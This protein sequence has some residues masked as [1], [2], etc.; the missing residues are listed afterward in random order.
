[1]A[2]HD[3]ARLVAASAVFASVL[4][5]ASMAFACEGAGVIVRIE[6][7]PQDVE[8]ARVENGAAILVSRPRVLEVVCRGDVIR[9]I[10]ET[11]IV[12]AID[13]A[14]S[15]RVSHNISYTVPG[16]SGVATVVGNAYQTIDEQVMPDMKRLPWNVR[17]KGAGD[18]FGFALPALS[19]GGQQLTIGKRSLLIR[20]VGG[21]A[22]YSVQVTD[23]KG[24]VVASQSSANHEVVLKDVSLS[25][26]LYRVTVGDATPRSLEADVTAVDAS[27]PHT[28]TFSGLADPEIRAA[29]AAT[30][31]ARDQPATWAL[32]AEQQLQAAP[33]NG[34]DRDKVYE[35]MESYGAD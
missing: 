9:T 14:G 11:Y 27:P 13:G 10:G 25:L 15:V 6:G 5:C 18:D 20:L 2:R 12:L 1:M 30:T 32:E 21:I 24:R 8:I 28:E 35:L 17:L 4:S 34:L 33:A 26:G 22:P 19:A 7:R 29:A 31:L 23:V 16:R 3:I